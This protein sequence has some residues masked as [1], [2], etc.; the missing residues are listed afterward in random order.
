MKK[1]LFVTEALDGHGG[2]ENVSRQVINYLNS[3]SAYDAGIYIIN[4][5]MRGCSA[6]WQQ[7]ILVG[8]SRAFTGNHKIRSG[9]NSLQLA[10]FIRRWLPDLVIV[11]T[12]RSCL[13]ARQ[14]LTISRYQATL[15]SWMHLPPADRYR[16]HYLKLADH[17]FAI[18]LGIASQLQQIGI[19][20]NTIDLVYNPVERSDN[21]IGRSS[22]FRMIFAGRVMFEGQKRMKDLLDAVSQ[23]D[24]AWTLDIV[25][26]GQDE[27]QCQLYARQLGIDKFITWHGWQ[28]DCW[29]YIEQNIGSLTCL[30]LTSES[31]GFPLIL[32]EAI[33]RGVFCIS[34]DCPTGPA[35]IINHGQNGYLYPA[36]QT[37]DLVKILK[38]LDQD[39]VL[40]EPAV[41]KESIQRFY[42]EN[43]YKNLEQ[44][45][46]RLLADKL[47]RKQK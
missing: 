35:E 3:T 21:T 38:T 1:I 11:M 14:A 46:L 37:K 31:E 2:T 12:T 20:Q 15:V 47:W 7:G 34:A 23:L 8:Q 33:S 42:P 36:G 44:Y 5:G 9:L 28:Y 22:E 25:G 10:L 32:L 39:R 4:H 45:L 29:Q 24:F 19:Q 30:L 17:H 26:G 40:P 13:N 27:Q 16:P 43:Y 6:Q 41:I 18:S